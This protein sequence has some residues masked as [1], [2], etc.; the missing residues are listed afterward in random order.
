MEKHSANDTKAILLIAD[1]RPLVY[2]A[3]VGSLDQLISP[4]RLCLLP[5]I[6]IFKATEDL[7]WALAPEIG[8][9]LGANTATYSQAP[10]WVTGQQ[11]IAHQLQIQ[12]TDFGEAYANVRWLHPL[13]SSGIAGSVSLESWLYDYIE[14]YQGDLLLLTDDH[15]IYDVA[16]LPETKAKLTWM[17]TRDYLRDREAQGQ[18]QGAEKIWENIQ[19]HNT[20]RK[21]DE[22]VAHR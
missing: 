12:Q 16:Q 19:W 13:E 4:H 21:L 14:A 8:A 3:S 2:L 7:R 15:K 10:S 11:Q 1:V 20:K 9:W 22:D 18:L 17:T 6:I 5:D